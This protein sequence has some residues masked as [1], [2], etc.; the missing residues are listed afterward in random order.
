MNLDPACWPDLAGGAEVVLLPLRACEQHGPHLP[1][2]TDAPIA[3][4]YGGLG[5]PTGSSAQEGA[6]RLAA[7]AA[8][9]R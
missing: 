8:A 4:R 9:S 5:D 1:F 7:H 3:A 6:G 2:H